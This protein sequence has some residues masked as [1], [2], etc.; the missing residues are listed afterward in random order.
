VEGREAR[1]LCGNRPV[2]VPPL[3]DAAVKDGDLV[4]A[5]PAQHPPQAR[6]HGA[7][8][9]VVAHHLIGRRQAASPHPLYEIIGI[10]KRV[11]PVASG[12]GRREIA[13]EVREQ[14]PRNMRFAVLLLP[15][16]GVGEIVPAVEDAPLRVCAELGGAD[17]GGW[18]RSIL[19]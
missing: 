6:R 18:H 10:G 8:A 13:I 14:R 2:F 1:E 4:V 3:R 5:D 16:R 7:V 17:Q 11:A 9:G 12:L 19:R 15:E